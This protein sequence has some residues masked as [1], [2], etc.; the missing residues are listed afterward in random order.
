MVGCTKPAPEL[1]Q[2]RHPVTPKMWDVAKSL[3]NVVVPDFSL[4]EGHSG[5]QMTLK[6]VTAGRPTIIYFIKDDCPCSIDVEPLMQKLAKGLGDKV[7]VVGVLNGGPAIYKKWMEIGKTP[8]AVLMD[9]ELSTIKKFKAERST[10]TALIRP[11]GTVDKLWPGYSAAMLSEL[12]ERAA[13]LA[14]MAV[15]TYDPAYAPKEMTSG[16]SFYSADP[17]A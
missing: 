10:Y 14:N 12:N 5:T 16:C 7:S 15:P 6:D 3:D 1:A 11:D 2:V 8:Y 13:K 4:T 17:R 9:P